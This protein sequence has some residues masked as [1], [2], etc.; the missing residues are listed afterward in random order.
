MRKATIPFLYSL[1]PTLLLALFAPPPVLSEVLS[2][3]QEQEIMDILRERVETYKVAPAIVVGVVSENGTQVIAHG[4]FSPGD[5][6]RPDGNT[7]FEIGSVTKVFTSILLA[8]MTLNDGIKLE[9]PVKQY[10][11]SIIAVPQYEGKKIT[12]EHLATHSSGLP[13]MPDNFHPADPTNPYQDY[14]VEHMYAF[15][16]GCKLTSEPGSSSE[17]TN[18]GVGLL[19]HSLSLA[20]KTDY[21]SLV[22]QKICEPLGMES[23]RITLS[24]ELDIRLA[25]GHGYG[26]QVVKNWDIPTFAGAG[27][28]RSTVNDMLKFL[29]ANMGLSENRLASAMEMTHR[30]RM[31]MEGENKIGLGWITSYRYDAEI[32]WH[33]GGTGGYH[34]FIGFRKDKAIGVVVLANANHTNL[35][36]DEIGLHILEEKYQLKELT[37][38]PIEIELNREIIAQYAGK[39]EL[40]PQSAFNFRLE[41]DRFTFQMTGQ[42]AYR[43]YPKSKSKF[44]VKEGD[45]QFAFGRN[46]HGDVTHVELHQAG[47]VST[48]IR[49]GAN[50]VPE[51]AFDEIQL[52]RDILARYVG[53]YEGSP[54]LIFTVALEEGKLMVQLPGQPAIQIFPRS[55]TEF[56]YRVV[57]A[58]ITFGLDEEGAATHLILHQN[59]IDSR[60]DR[61]EEELEP[62]EESSPKETRLS[63]EFLSRYVGIYEMQPG[64]KFYV[65]LNQDRLMVQL[66][67]QPAFQVFPESRTVFFYKAVDA[68]IRF[69]SESSGKVTGLVLEQGG[70]KMPATKIK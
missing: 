3:E 48:A 49:E 55:E 24:D 12:L 38:P 13:R 32:K 70:Q 42:P 50:Y 62:G 8:D 20:A 68:K 52:D 11:P 44:F 18:L 51:S 28:L 59:G 35:D 7:V 19:G 22:I 47:T 15:L 21:E 43:I 33:N 56:F 40:S 54:Q 4:T 41:E 37:L 29:T 53:K 46:N 17:Y 9:D 25:P 5:D 69:E 16:V 1:L 36:I 30:A 31:N 61:Q 60:A 6:R 10:L 58:Q 14:T 39:Y 23:T 2:D 34:S 45:V 64:V 27:A 63:A 66:T 26:C 67:G 65:E 57:D